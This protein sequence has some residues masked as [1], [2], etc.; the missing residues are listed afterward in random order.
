MYRARTR[1]L[2]GRLKVGGPGSGRLG[3]TLEQ[4]L[5][6]GTLRVARLDRVARAEARVAKA[7]H[8]RFLKVRERAIERVAR[9]LAEEAAALPVQV[10]RRGRRKHPMRREPVEGDE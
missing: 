10:D 5:A 1:A 8:R 3:L 7:V 2:R 6:R 4:H 9:E